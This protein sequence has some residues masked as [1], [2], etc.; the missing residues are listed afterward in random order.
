MISPTLW[1]IV[2]EFNNWGEGKANLTVYNM[3]GQQL[4]SIT[5][6]STAKGRQEL[7]LTGIKPGYYLLKVTTQDELLYK[8]LYLS[9]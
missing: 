8:K 3:L 5:D 4:N 6:V 7:Q 1:V 9:E 2:V